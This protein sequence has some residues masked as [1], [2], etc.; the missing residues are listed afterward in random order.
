MLLAIGTLWFW[1][2]LA[3]FLILEFL[4]IE[5]WE[6]GIGAT[7]TLSVFLAIHWFWGDPSIF[8]WI[9]DNPETIAFGMLGYFVTG[10][11]WGFVKWFLHLKEKAR[12][13]QEK[14][15]EFLA[16]KGVKKADLSTPVP[17][18]LREDWRRYS[19]YKVARPKAAQNKSRIIT[20][21]AYW[22]WSAMWTMI[23]DPFVHAY[24][25]CAERLEKM[26]AKVFNNIGFEQD[27]EIPPLDVTLG[28][29][30]KNAD[31]GNIRYTGDR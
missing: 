30:E 31:G 18:N 28:P 23:R 26:S 25:F 22:P 11:V 20:W 29:D 10:C 14:R 8:Q 27:H 6:N 19:Q 5:A 2:F 4:W 24:N 17:E 21:M 7:I 15:L 3:T 16:G 9:G 12:E 13:Y 1:L